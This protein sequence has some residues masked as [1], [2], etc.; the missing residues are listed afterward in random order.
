MV[1]NNRVPNRA[2]ATVSGPGAGIAPGLV[3]QLGKDLIR[4]GTVGLFVGV[5][6][7]I[8]APNQ[9]TRIGIVSRHITAH[10]QL[11]TAITNNDFVFNHSRGTSN[12]V[13]LALINGDVAPNYSTRLGVQSFQ[14]TV[15]YSDKYLAFVDRQTAV[16]H[17]TTAFGRVFS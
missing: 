15:K 16:N 1:I 11:S 17:V 9:L 3:G 13:G 14:S 5:G 12:R 7:R 8:K 6:N 10:T 4:D 2:A